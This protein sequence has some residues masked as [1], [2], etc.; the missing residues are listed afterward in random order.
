MSAV[1]V[2]ETPRLRLRGHRP[3]DL[4]AYAAMWADAS[5][6]RHIG[7]VPLTREQSWVRILQYRGLWATLGFG[8]WVVED[9][10]SGLLL[11][12]AGMQDMRRE[13][14]PGLGGALECGW[15]LV[16]AAQGRG[17][18]EE[19]M[20][21]VLGWAGRERKGEPLACIIAPA[22]AP[23]QRL[24]AKLGFALSAR[25]TYRGAEVDIWR[26]SH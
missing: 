21:A 7:G 13:M 8:F 19:A 18:A 3:D 20:R 14:D 25:A 2:L 26:K 15:G 17:L 12:E 9:R 5:V 22:N 6:V 23:S 11:G 4:D 24:A 1:P 16:P 10:E